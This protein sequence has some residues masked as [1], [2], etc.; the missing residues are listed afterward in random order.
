MTLLQALMSFVGF[1]LCAYVADLQGKRSKKS[2][3]LISCIVLTFCVGFRNPSVWS[4]TGIYLISFSQTPSL[5]NL[6]ADSKPYGF[7]EMGFY[8]IGV[9]VK[10]FTNSSVVYF[11]LISA[12]SFFFLYKTLRKYSIYPMLGLAIYLA[13][14]YTGRNMTQIRACLAIAIIIYFTYF[15]L[16]KKWWNYLLVIVISYTLHHSAMVAFPLLLLRRYKIK[17]KW[18]YA[19]IIVSI[20]IAGMYGSFIRT[21]VQNSG[22]MQDMGGSYVQEGSDKAFS[23]TL[24]NPVI[25]YQVF[26]LFCF[27]YFEDRLKKLSPYYFIMRNGYF[28]CTCILIVM[29]QYA[30]VAARTSTIFATFEIVMVPMLVE[31]W[32][33]KNKLAL[34]SILAIPYIFLFA[35]N[36]SPHYQ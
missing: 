13:R 21:W 26:I 34:Y 23:N 10:T 8:Y 29:C 14:F 22:F 32:G 4:D 6:T 33:R 35:L 17:E 31:M 30:V 25:W 12:L 28:Y 7:T 16:K 18:I 11:T 24:A 5:F 9:F 19:G 20:I 3:L 27:T 15:I 36:W 2:L 1:L